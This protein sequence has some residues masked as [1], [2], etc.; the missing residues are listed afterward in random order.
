MLAGIKNNSMNFDRDG[1]AVVIAFY[2]I[3]N[4]IAI[5]SLKKAMKLLSIYEVIC[6][7][8]FVSII[9]NEFFVIVNL[10]MKLI[11]NTESRILYLLITLN[12]TVLIPIVIIWLLAIILNSKSVK[13]Q[14]FIIILFIL[15]LTFLEYLGDWLGLTHHK[16]WNVLWTVL[17]W[18]GVILLTLLF[19]RYVKHLFKKEVMS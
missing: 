15:V 9:G 12:R 8:L 7:G 1:F 18:S 19:S 3:I 11:E 17:E 6:Y 4:F 2:L 13:N 14:A 5:L 16:D 10:N